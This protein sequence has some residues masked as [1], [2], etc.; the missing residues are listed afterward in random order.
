MSLPRYLSST[1]L[2]VFYCLWS[3]F[4]I[5][6][7]EGLGRRASPSTVPQTVNPLPLP[8]YLTTVVVAVN[9]TT[10]NIFVH[11]VYGIIAL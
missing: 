2:Y 9:C 8:R 7:G 11:N 4:N 10:M 5:E 6:I 3:N 1:P